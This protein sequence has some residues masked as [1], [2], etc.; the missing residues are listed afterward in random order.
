[1]TEPLL[2]RLPDRLLDRLLDRLSGLETEYAIRFTPVDGSEAPDN[3]VVYEAIEAALSTL[4]LTRK[5]E[6]TRQQFF[7]EN[8]GAFAYEFLPY[9]PGGGLIE[10]ATPECRGPSE[11]LLYQRAQDALLADALPLAQALLARQGFHGSL[12]ALKNCRDAEGHVYGA[13][14]N[15]EADIARGAGLWLWRA[16]LAALVPLIA[17]TALLSWAFF[18][19]LIGLW[20]IALV[21]V[22]LGALVSQDERTGAALQELLF[23]SPARRL[24]RALGRFEFILYGHLLWAPAL[25]LFFGLFRLVAFRRIRRDALAFLMTRCILTGAGTLEADG[26]LGLSEKAPSIRRVVRLWVSQED[27]AVFDGGNLC[28]ALLRVTSLDV[29]RFARLFRRRQRMQLG[30][31]DSNMAQVAEYL[32]LGTTG[33]VL[34]MAEAGALDDLPRLRRPIDALHGIAADATLSARVDVV[35]GPPMRALDIQRAYLARA[36]RFVQEAPI[37]SIEAADLVVLWAR[38]LEARAASLDNRPTSLVGHID[39]ATKQYL[40]DTAGKDASHA[41]RKKIDLKYHELGCGYF[42]RLEARGL[43][44]M[45]WSAEDIA[46]ARETPPQT[47]PARVRGRVIRDLGRSDMRVRVAWD[48][49]EVGPSVG[50]TVI[51]LDDYRK[52]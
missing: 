39:W 36:R 32:K 13:Q 21:L 12:G 45:I 16:G 34:D 29:R 51:R 7:L 33:L 11:T 3:D 1:M 18:A 26:V 24:E 30:L 50:G 43:A 25:W 19:I 4:V 6:G 20:V 31:S 52:R 2:G 47:T 42:A 48:R 40:I 17:A 23:A 35:D 28:K 10:G 5:G 38:A 14:E 8:G 46:R 27:R 41:V 44:P 22:G 49:I 15:Y 37:R 9:A